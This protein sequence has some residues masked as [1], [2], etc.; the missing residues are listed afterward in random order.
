M[1]SQSRFQY[2]VALF[3]FPLFLL[4]CAET[5][6]NSTASAETNTDSSLTTESTDNAVNSTSYQAKLITE[7]MISGKQS[8]QIQL[9]NIN[10]QTPATSKTLSLKPMMEMNTGMKHSTPHA[11]CN[12]TETLGTYQCDI[13]FLM[14]SITSTGMEMGTW[15]LELAI[16]G[17]ESL[18]FKP[19]V[20]P[21]L[22]NAATLQG[23]ND[24]IAS[25]VM[26]DEEIDSGM[27]MSDETMDTEMPMTE[28]RKYHLFLHHHDENK[29]QIFIAARESL[30]QFPALSS[31]STLSSN[32]DYE[33]AVNSLQLQ[34]ST[35][36]ENWTTIVQESNGLWT[37]NQAIPSGNIYLKLEVNGETK[38][39]NGLAPDETNTYAIITL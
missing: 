7:E 33:I 2:R 26:A 12:E 4:S 17:N 39:T 6:D 11:G 20:K 22:G 35:D 13:Y 8:F 3:A 19:Q 10:D 31:G 32:T 16:D 9:N 14:P 5:D 23:Q 27:A 15:T 36:K 1:V 37:H 24:Q 38:T 21:A 18:S 30:M 28:K 34:I 29:L 25:T